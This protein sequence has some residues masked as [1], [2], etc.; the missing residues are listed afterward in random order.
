MVLLMETCEGPCCYTGGLG[1]IPS[2]A[3]TFLAKSIG[4]PL[5]L[6]WLYPNTITTICSSY[7][8]FF[9]SQ[10]FSGYII[11]LSLIWLI[12]AV[13]VDTPCNTNTWHGGVGWVWHWLTLPRASVDFVLVILST[14]NCDFVVLYDYQSF[15]TDAQSF[16]TCPSW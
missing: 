8:H 9:L 7:G 2:H 12:E 11:Y 4:S 3:I 10:Q 5:T 1:L 15:N 14:Y 6:F 13:G 16:L